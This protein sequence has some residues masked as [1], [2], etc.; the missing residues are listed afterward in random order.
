MIWS[1]LLLAGVWRDRDVRVS[2]GCE[3]ASL[4]V[5]GQ[6]YGVVVRAVPLLLLGQWLDIG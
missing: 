2:D 4:S 3:Q 5:M 1:L 6:W